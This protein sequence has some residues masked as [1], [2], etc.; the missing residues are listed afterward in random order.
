MIKFLNYG[1]LYRYT[2]LTDN[3]TTS[4]GTESLNQRS[5]I[6][7]EPKCVAADRDTDHS[8]TNGGQRRHPGSEYKET[9]VCSNKSQSHSA[10]GTLRK[11]FV[12]CSVTL[13]TF[14]GD[15]LAANND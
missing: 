3:S 12:E 7:G 8:S 9:G 15:R 5:N 14:S 2:V 10:A 1:L 6:Y 13:Y 4:N 11:L